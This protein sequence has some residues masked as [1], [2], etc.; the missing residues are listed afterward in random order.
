MQVREKLVYKEEEEVHAQE[1][2][3]RAESVAL[4]RWEGGLQQQKEALGKMEEMLR[5]PY[6]PLCVDHDVDPTIAIEEA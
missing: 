4:A 3:Q 1:E 2:R 6:R 5:C